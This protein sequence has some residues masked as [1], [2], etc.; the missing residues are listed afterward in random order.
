VDVSTKIALCSSSILA[1]VAATPAFASN[2]APAPAASATQDSTTQNTP[3]P[4]TDAAE[5]G[6]I[7]VTARKQSESILRTPIAVTA[8][9]GDQLAVRGAVSLNDVANLTPGVNIN[10]NAAGRNDRSFQQIIIRGFT[11][12]AATNPTTSLFIDG[13]PVSSPTAFLGVSDPERV[14]TL[15]GPQSAYF[16]RNTFA[17][18]INVVNKEPGDHLA[19][20]VRAEVGTR[21][22]YKLHADIGGP[23]LGD[24]VL[25]RLS[26]DRF[27][28]D[29]SYTNAFNTNQTLGDQMTTSGSALLVIKPVDGLRIKAFGLISQDED[30]PSAQAQLSAY[31]I[32]DAAGNLVAAN[33][34]NCTLTGRSAAGAVVSNPFFCGTAPKFIK[35]L[36]PSA[37]TINDSVIKNFLANPTGR[38]VSPE[39]GVK[40]YGLLRRYY[41]AHVAIDWDVGDTGVTLSSL[42]GYNNERY[43]QLTDLDNF[44]TTGIP[45]ITT[46]AAL[47]QGARTYFDYP[48][49]VERI[50]HDFS[51][52]LRATYDGGPLHITAGASYLNAFSQGSLGGGNGALGVSTFSIVSGATRNKTIGGFGGVTYKFTDVFSLSAEGRYQV[53]K[54]YAYAQPGGLTATTNSFV[55]AGFYAAGSTILQKD[56]TSFTPRVIA[57]AQVTPDTMFY[58]S[59]SKGINPG[60][61]NTAFLTFSAPLQRA[62]AAAG[63]TV[64]V[65][66][67]KV[68]NWEIGMKGRF[69]DN[70][71]RLSIDAYYAPWR[72]Q[73][74]AITFNAFDPVTNTVQIV[75]GSANTGAVNMK[76]IEIDGTFNPIRQL[77]LNFG[78]AITDSSIVKFQ[79]AI[80]TQLSGITDFKGKE[81]P[82]T[83]KFSA[84]A[85]AQYNGTFGGPDPIGWFM[86]GD[87]VFKSG[88][89]SD[90]ANL[91]HTPDM[92]KVNARVGITRGPVTIDAAITNLFNNRAYVTIADNSV[93][94]NN[95]RYSNYS[96]GLIV[97]LPDLRTVTLGVKYKF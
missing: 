25:F 7:V 78:G 1:F 32:R 37:N 82:N 38:V 80:V 4:A 3:S 39:D 90:A 41:H 27:A 19:G 16:G 58:A 33:Q 42:T 94:T 72:N 34:S 68:T 47:A 73:I 10:N 11:P 29:G 83:S 66:P 55:P 52:E 75:R 95:F 51:Q 9:S 92:H 70:R 18:A 57:Q 77:D 71:L 88:V 40:G 23:L 76:G 8:L 65:A 5:H 45:N 85:G 93:L 21:E 14:E 53:D 74:N 30:G 6:E 49:I 36:N 22:N 79:N 97:G 56:Y 46:A 63:I 35:G 26:A 84:T 44:G 12:S 96:S 20:S 86:R 15:K 13:V 87:Y 50:N 67:E 89:F 61:F 81:N 64:D 54:L 24:A 17:G 62:A 59:F 48:Y 91:V 28:K 60:L 43:S 2:V 69:F 31:E